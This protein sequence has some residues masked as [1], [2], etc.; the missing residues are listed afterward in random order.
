GVGG[1]GNADHVA[2]SSGSLSARRPTQTVWPTFKPAQQ[3]SLRRV[4]SPAL[5]PCIE[6]VSARTP[7]VTPPP[8]AIGEPE[9]RPVGVPLDQRCLNMTVPR[10][11]NGLSI[12][13]CHTPGWN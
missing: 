6:T 5:L 13:A 9:D 10:A 2:Q 7:A 8:P 1:P 3:K 12:A 4:A 11:P